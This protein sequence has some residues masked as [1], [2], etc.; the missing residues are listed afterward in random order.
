MPAC[1]LSQNPHGRKDHSLAV[2]I[3]N[4]IQDLGLIR[5]RSCPSGVLTV[6]D[7]QQATTTST[8][9]LVIVEPGHTVSGAIH[10]RERT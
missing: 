6:S 7:I 5:H 9:G 10:S 8:Q 1:K 2:I 4:N 3:L